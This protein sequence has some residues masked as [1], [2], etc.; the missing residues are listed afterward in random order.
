M[1]RWS[2]VR[3]LF[4]LVSLLLLALLRPPAP[5]RCALITTQDAWFGLA[6]PATATRTTWVR[7]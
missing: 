6:S 7:R 5:P 4:A 2:A 1:T 3:A